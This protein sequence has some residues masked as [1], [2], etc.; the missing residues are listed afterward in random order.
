[1]AN[2]LMHPWPHDEGHFVRT[3]D[4]VMARVEEWLRR[5]GLRRELVGGPNRRRLARG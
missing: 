2:E 1:L 3:H 4:A 5:G